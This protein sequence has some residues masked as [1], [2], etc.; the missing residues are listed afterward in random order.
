MPLYNHL[1]EWPWPY[2]ARES[3]ESV[4][5]ASI[6]SG[7]GSAGDSSSV[8]IVTLAGS[9]EDAWCTGGRTTRSTLG[10]SFWTLRR[11]EGGDFDSRVTDVPTDHELVAQVL[12]MLLVDGERERGQGRSAPPSSFATPPCARV[13]SDARRAPRRTTPVAI[14][15]RSTSTTGSRRRTTGSRRKQWTADA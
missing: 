10:L 2:C 6:R 12:T 3:D 5:L 8:T 14:G 1:G 4:P 11:L 15:R 9:D 13:P 7:I